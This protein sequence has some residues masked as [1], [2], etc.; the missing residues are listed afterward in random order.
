M[1]IEIRD[2]E[3][4]LLRDLMYKKT[5]VFLKTT[6]KPLISARLRK[7]LEEL[8]FSNFQDYVMLLENDS[9]SELEIFINALTTNETFFFRHTKQFNYLYEN[10]FPA[11]REK[12]RSRQDEITIWCAAC[13]TGEEPYSIAIASKEFFKTEQSFKV[14]ILAS[15]I[16]S[17][18]IQEAKAGVYS[19]R[20]VKDV[21]K[22]LLAKYFQPKFFGKNESI[23]KYQLSDIIRNSVTFFEHNLLTCFSKKNIDIIFLRNVMIYFDAKSKQTVVSNVEANLSPGGHFFISLSESLNDVNTSL[24]SVFSGVFQKQG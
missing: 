16:N 20:S 7:R 14:N 5:G 4:N 1:I 12:K 17:G 21:P 3:F 10:V 18:V 22:S 23:R 13:S 11:L 6:K 19:E 9:G 24:T 15:D 8:G 2:K